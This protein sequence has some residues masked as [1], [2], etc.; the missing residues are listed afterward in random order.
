MITYDSS[1]S[2]PNV[3]KH[4]NTNSKISIID[5]VHSH[6]IYANMTQRYI[7]LFHVVKEALKGSP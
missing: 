3:I 4:N 1:Y 2:P 6:Q 5:H 7:F